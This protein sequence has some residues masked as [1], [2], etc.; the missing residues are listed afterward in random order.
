[1]DLTERDR[2]LASLAGS[3]G[4]E[5]ADRLWARPTSRWGG[6]SGQELYELGCLE[7]LRRWVQE[8]CEVESQ[9]VMSVG[10]L[11][12]VIFQLLHR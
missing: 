7:T 8:V 11:R 6:L 10:E 5:R 2:L 1:V 9:S 3:V 4:P 12:S